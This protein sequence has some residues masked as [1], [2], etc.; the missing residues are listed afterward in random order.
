MTREAPVACRKA[1]CWGVQ[2]CANSCGPVRVFSCR[3]PIPPPKKNNSQV[4][5][6]AGE[7]LGFAL[8]AVRGTGGWTGLVAVAATGQLAHALLQALPGAPLTQ[9]AVVWSVIEG[10]RKASLARGR[11]EQA[12]PQGQA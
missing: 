2:T 1:P 12:A 11:A 9:A 6:F 10:L 4:L 8:D 7:G 3:P 5:Q